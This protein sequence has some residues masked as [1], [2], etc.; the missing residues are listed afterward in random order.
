MQI[1]IIILRIL[2][3][4]KMIKHLICLE[5]FELKMIFILI[6]RIIKILKI[7]NYRLVLIEIKLLLIK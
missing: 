5:K 6:E 1:N 3:I 2:N 4:I 7:I